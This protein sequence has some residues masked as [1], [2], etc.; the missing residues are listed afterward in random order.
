[1]MLLMG[2]K[3]GGPFASL[4]RT[5]YFSM[6]I[7]L[8]AVT[9]AVLLL[10]RHFARDLHKYRRPFVWLNLFYATTLCVWAC[11]ITFNDQYGGSGLNVFIYMIITVAAFCP[12]Q[13]WQSTA[14]FGGCFALL[15]LV[16]PALPHGAENIFNNLTNSFFITVMAIFLSAS[17]YRNRVFCQHNRDVIQRQYE[18]IARMNERLG[19]QVM[20]DQLTRMKNRRYLEEVVAY[21]FSER[22][23]TQSVGGLMIDIDFFKQYNDTFGH[24]KGDECLRDI[25]RLILEGTYSDDAFV[26]RYGGEEFFI[27]VFGCTE[28][29]IASAAQQIRSAIEAQ[30][31]PRSDLPIGRVTVSVGVCWGCAPFTMTLHELVNRA[32]RALYRAKHD[33]RNRVALFNPQK[34]SEADFASTT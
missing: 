15:N 29:E 8:F 13:V 3:A 32:D 4:R 18:K 10:N 21:E 17:L 9:L 27:C 12:L 11:G 26:V 28:K 2:T 33:G 23:Q 20:T 5:R 6:Y 34:A 16:L 30:C 25:S 24:L 7:I 1:M 31:F 22:R 19:E 14:L